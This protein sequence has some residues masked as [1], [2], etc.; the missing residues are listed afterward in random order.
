MLQTTIVGSLPKPRW[1]SDP[2]VLRA[3]WR[4]KGDELH[5]A[6]DDAVRLALIE[7]EEAGLDVV[8]DGEQRRRHYIWGFLEGLTGT[9]TEKLAEKRA[10]GGRYSEST[11]VARINGEVTR[12]GPVFLEAV[13]FARAHTKH[14]LKITLPGP[15]TIVDSVLDE[16]YRS[17]EKSL[18]LRFAELLNAEARELAAAGADVIQFDEPCFNIYVDKV[19]EWGIEALE[20]A[21]AGVAAKKAVHICY[22][23][24]T[25]LVLKWK[26]QNRDWGHYGFTLP[27]LA[28]SGVDQVSVECAA[29]G[30][31]VSVL[32]A[33][34]GKDVMLGVIDVGT[35]EVE[36]PAK[37]AERIRAALPH[38]PPERLMPCTDCGLVP[39]S[40]AAALGKMRALA[41]GAAMVRREL[42]R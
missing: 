8:C 16:H 4:L 37:V 33:L 25:P 5:E 29:S 32:A 15:M 13:R 42:G 35:E 20:R 40:R 30:V 7:Q 10:R 36:S 23:Y 3:P 28:E 6:Q 11:P 38:V 18:A 27:L 34:R 22:G 21:M 26:K 2:N 1:L 12:P 14:A 31:D 19:K 17:D 24:G 9:D 39:R 41:E